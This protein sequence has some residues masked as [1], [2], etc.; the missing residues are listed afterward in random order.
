MDANNYWKLVNDYDKFK[1]IDYAPL[2]DAVDSYREIANNLDNT[3]DLVSDLSDMSGILHNNNLNEI[4]KRFLAEIRKHE[5][6]F[7]QHSYKYYETEMKMDTYEDIHEYYKNIHLIPEVKEVIEG[8]IG[9]AINWQ[10]PGMEL[11][12]GV[13]HFTKKL[14]G[15][16]PLYIVD[17]Y[18]QSLE[19]TKNHFS[20]AYQHRLRTYRIPGDADFRALPQGQMG[21]IFSFGFFE[22][23]PLDVIKVYLKEFWSL[24]RPSGKVIITYN[25]CLQ[26]ASLDN[27]VF[28]HYRLFNTKNYMESAV[29]GSGF[30]RIISTD[31]SSNI[32]VLEFEKPGEFFT[33]RGGQTLGKIKKTY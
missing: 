2:I 26:K 27:T 23:L 4:D 20:E 24:L 21:M 1:Q 10:Y 22:R 31:V 16:D 28:R 15:L 17:K 6:A 19:T 25:N 18:K 33:Q 8:K 30:D 13:N 9:R 11:S 5:V 32:T 12:P 14:V 7:I 3:Y 29:Y